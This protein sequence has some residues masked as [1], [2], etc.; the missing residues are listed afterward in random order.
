MNTKG[1]ISTGAGMAATAAASSIGAGTAIGAAAGP[2]GAAAGL[3]VGLA[4]SANHPYGTCAP[5]A[6]D[7][8]SFLKCWSHA[9]PDNYMPVWTNMW[10]G[11]DG[12]GWVYCS[13]ARAGQ[14]PAG[15]CQQVGQGGQNYCGPDGVSYKLPVGSGV[16]NPTGGPCA[17]PGTVQSM[18]GGGY[19]VVPQTPA[20]GADVLDSGLTALE[21]GSVAGIPTW[22][23]LAL[24]GLGVYAA[25]R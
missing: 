23:I 14:P 16:R 7:M 5:N 17:P 1:L 20:A 10:G 24:A 21:S 18:R 4:L 22:M 25:T 19:D 2:I 8:A 11:S 6:K 3:L 15:G 13:G 12:K 9:I